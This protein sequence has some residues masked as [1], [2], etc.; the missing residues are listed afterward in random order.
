M[1]LRVVMIAALCAV[2]FGTY[3]RVAGVNPAHWH[4]DPGTEDAPGMR[5]HF[6]DLADS[7]VWTVPSEELLAKVQEIALQTRGTILLAGNPRDGRL[8]FETRSRVWGFPDYTT[9][10]VSDVEGGS[11]LAVLGR[12]RFGASDLGTNEARIAAWIDALKDAVPAQ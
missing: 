9:F 6:V 12:A 4:V 1:I 11:A 5:G 2:L 3:V 8:T 10:D 7:P